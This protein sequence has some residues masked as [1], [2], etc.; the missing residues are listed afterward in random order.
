M[1]VE[2]YQT[3][4]AYQL[5]AIQDASASPLGTCDVEYFEE[6]GRVPA[7][8]CV[9]LRMSKEARSRAPLISPDPA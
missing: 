4:Q 1:H 7:P 5:Q 6:G 3:F 9:L 2:V 8:T